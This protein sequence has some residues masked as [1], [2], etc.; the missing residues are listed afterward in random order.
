[1]I[2]VC[3]GS[4]NYQFDRLIKKLD[5][6][7]EKKE[8]KDTVYAQIGD[9]NYF[10]KNMQYK[11]FIDAEEYKRCQEK[12]D[13]VITHGGTGSIVGALKNRKNV[14]AVPRLAKYGEH[15]DDHQLQIVRE[16]EKSGYL[17][18]VEDIDELAEKIKF[19][20]QGNRLHKFESDGLMVDIIK[21]YINN[22]IKK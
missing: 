15:I 8:I 7:V 5:E 22:S 6:L 2:F 1:M 20:E 17:L 9:G 16:F 18:A 4:R 21:E 14:I 12:A 10:P 13:I 19:F 11:N 3:T